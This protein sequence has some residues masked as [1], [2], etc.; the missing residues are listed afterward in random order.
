[1]EPVGADVAVSGSMARSPVYQFGEAATKV[2]IEDLFYAVRARAFIT[3]QRI[4]LM[5]Q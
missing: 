4:K 2:I 1:M 5:L 3:R